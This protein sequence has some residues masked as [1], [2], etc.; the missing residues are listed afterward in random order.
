MRMIPLSIAALVGAAAA[1]PAN[2]APQ[3]AAQPSAKVPKDGLI[4][5][6][7]QVTGSRLGSRQV[8]MRPEAW[9]ERRL[10]ERQGVEH[11]QAIPCM[12]TSTDSRGHSQC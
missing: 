7:Q 12:P 5:E 3:Q 8:C 1:S 2:A 9:A 4:C 10:Q 6:R 11:T